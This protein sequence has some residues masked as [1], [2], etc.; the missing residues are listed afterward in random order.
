MQAIFVVHSVLLVHSGRQFG[1]DPINSGKQ[2]QSP[3]FP[4]SVQTELGPHGEGRH[5]FIATGGEDAKD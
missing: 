1:G 5:G 2:R 3:L 4:F